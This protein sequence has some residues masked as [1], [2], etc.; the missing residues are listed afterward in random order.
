MRRYLT[1]SA[2]RLVCPRFEPA[3]GRLENVTPEGTAGF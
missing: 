1:R 3:A 2:N